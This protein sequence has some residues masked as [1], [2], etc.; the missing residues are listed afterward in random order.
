MPW[1]GVF[2][3]PARCYRQHPVAE[4]EPVIADASKNQTI[5]NFKQKLVV[6]SV[7]TGYPTDKTS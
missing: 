3:R 1:T 5:S 4:A 7:A 6:Q 2:S